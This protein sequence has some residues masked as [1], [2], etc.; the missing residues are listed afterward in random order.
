LAAS[1]AGALKAKIEGLGL[2]ISV[3]RDRAP[4]KT[5][6]PYV[7]VSE[8]IA[9]VPDLL[10]DGATSTGKETVSI[11][12]WQQWKVVATGAVAESYTLPGAIVRGI[13]G[14]SLA[15]APTRAYAVIVHHLGPRLVD[16]ESNIVHTVIQAV[17]WR[18][19]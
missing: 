7:T 15:T 1:T 19:L 13:H 5:A 8:S 4:E 16:E 17:V 3:Y 12:L 14:Q 2:S 11:D 18:V 9:V 6:L 10:E